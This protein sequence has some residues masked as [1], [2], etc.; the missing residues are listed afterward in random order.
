MPND[1]ACYV[2]S[3]YTKWA[4]NVIIHSLIFT[5]VRQNSS[6]TC[7]RWLHVKNN[8]FDTIKFRERPTKVL[9]FKNIF[10]RL[11]LETLYLMFGNSNLS[12]LAKKKSSEIVQEYILKI[13]EKDF[14]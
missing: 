14:L 7:E 2:T 6:C 13:L 1:F 10:R 11:E 3:T 9:I 8:T 12:L 4:T 5:L